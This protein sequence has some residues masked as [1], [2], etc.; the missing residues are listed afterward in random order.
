MTA[1]IFV[2]G[3]SET[4]TVTCTKDGKVKQGKWV[5]KVNPTVSVPAGYTQLEYI[6]SNG[7]QYIDTGISA[8]NGFKAILDWMF[9]DFSGGNNKVVLG[10]EES[11]SPWYCNWLRKAGA[12]AYCWSLGAY[13]DIGS[14]TVISVN[15]RYDIDMSTIK[16]AS[17]LKIDGDSIITDMN[18]NI[19]SSNALYIFTCNKAGTAGDSSS[20]RLYS[21]EIIKDDETVRNYIPAKR[22]SDGVIGLYDL[23]SNSFFTNAGTG[24]FTAGTEIPSATSGWLFDK[25]KSYGTYTITATNGTDTVTQDVLVDMATEFDIEMSYIKDRLLTSDD[26]QNGTF[27]NGTHS[28]LTNQENGTDGI[29]LVGAASRVYNNQ[30]LDAYIRLD[31]AIDFTDYSKLKFKAKKVVDH[32]VMLVVVTDGLKN[33]SKSWDDAF[34]NSSSS[35][36]TE[37]LTVAYVGVTKSYKELTANVWNDYEIDVSNI[38]GE[39][40]LSFVGGYTDLSGY[41]SSET[42]YCDIWLMK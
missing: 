19:R 41:S 34:G 37:P 4:D 27:K 10:S 33:T 11:G 1:E 39:H 40:V 8:P 13:S 24:T 26:F 6:E 35:T 22:N 9:T 5:S 21:C 2:T 23:V 17:Y 16:G 20:A 38:T 42:N 36:Y 28:I 31:M 29:R 32:G 25:L 14:S 15:T 12:S 30:S 18:S 3:L 7:T